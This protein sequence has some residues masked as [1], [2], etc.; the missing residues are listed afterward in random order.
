MDLKQL[1]NQALN[2][3]LVQQGRQKVSQIS[4]NTD[5]NQLK[6]L[7]LG[8][9]GGGLIGLLMGSK[10]SKKWGGTA[11]KVG[12]VAAL[13]ALAYK[14]YNDHQ[15]NQPQPAPAIEFDE[16]NPRHELLVLK[17][18]IAAAKADG[19]VDPAEMAQIEEAMQALGADN[20]V[21][22]LVEQELAKPI[23][24]AEIAWLARSPAQAAEIYLAS[25][26]VI[27]EQNFMEKAYLEELAKQLQLDPELVASLKE[28]V[29]SNN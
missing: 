18:I 17:A 14:L 7:G 4:Q 16:S 5:S 1:L 13:G 27:D 11:L 23:D 28:Q 25:L 24:P 22:T 10:K 29:K 12:G 3:D 9:A 2:S 8:A 19:H 6:T 20:T 21:Q 15:K 26:V